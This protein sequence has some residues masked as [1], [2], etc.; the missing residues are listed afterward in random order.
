MIVSAYF[1]GLCALMLVSSTA[2]VFGLQDASAAVPRPAMHYLRQDEDWSA[3]RNVDRS[4]LRWDDR[5]KYVA[6]NEDGSHYVTFGGS[7]RVRGESWNNF[8]FQDNHDRFAISRL[9]AHADLH[10]DHLRVFGELLTAQNTDRD[11]P[12]G[13]R[14]TDMTTLDVHQLFLELP[15]PL[16]IALRV[17][18]ESYDFGQGRLIG[19]APWGR[20]VPRAWEGATGRRDLFGWSWTGF[21]GELVL[22][23]PTDFD[24]RSAGDKLWGA[25]G[26]RPVGEAGLRSDAYV[27]GRQ[28]SAITYNGTTGEEDRYTVG[29]RLYRNK[30]HEHFDFDVEAAYQFGRVGSGDVN[31]YMLALE[32]GYTFEGELSPRTFAGLDYATGDDGA[33]GDVETFSQLLPRGHRHLGFVDVV[34]RQNILSTRLGVSIQPTAAVTLAATGYVFR[35]DDPG[36]ALY[37]VAAAPIIPGGTSSTKSVGEEL[38]LTALTRIGRNVSLL[39]GYSHFFGGRLQRDAGLEEDVDFFYISL[40]YFL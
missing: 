2:P 19:P 21:W 34:G 16:A 35:L 9:L 8:N 36:D 14:P 4:L 28:Q 24:E 38:D 30:G 12:G 11:L 10:L 33:G 22:P 1:R 17:G 31:A 29:G 3:L 5:I 13:R 40:E 18:R 20:N 32:G 6:L 23:D 15:I 37:N 27:I 25:Y 26:T 7:A 39:V